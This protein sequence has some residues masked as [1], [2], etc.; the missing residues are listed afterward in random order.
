[1]AV[2]ALETLETNCKSSPI[3]SSVKIL[4]ILYSIILTSIHWNKID[5]MTLLLVTHSVDLE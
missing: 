4:T 1:M 3:E 2:E 5:T